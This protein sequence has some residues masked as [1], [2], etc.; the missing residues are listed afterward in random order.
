[1]SVMSAPEDLRRS[2]VRFALVILV[3]LAIFFPVVALSYPQLVSDPAQ[4]WWA[5]LASN[6]VFELMLLSFALV[7]WQPSTLRFAYPVG[8]ASLCFL[9]AY[10]TAWPMFDHLGFQLAGLV[11]MFFACWSIV[12]AHFGEE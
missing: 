8:R 7:L 9:V 2:L 5:N 6:V 3:P 10:A 4:P 12:P 1:M 11:S